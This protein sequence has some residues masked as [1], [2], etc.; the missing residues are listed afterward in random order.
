MAR[1]WCN[2]AWKNAIVSKILNLELKDQGL[3]E[4]ANYFSE[5]VNCSISKLKKTKVMVIVLEVAALI[6]I[7]LLPVLFAP[8][9]SLK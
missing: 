8:K 3:S 9:R 7:I 4:G 1:L 2:W 6:A 5:N